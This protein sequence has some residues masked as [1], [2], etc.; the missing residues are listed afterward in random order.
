MVDFLCRQAKERTDWRA[1]KSL[2][3]LAQMGRPEALG[4]SIELGLAYPGSILYAERSPTDCLANNA[5]RI[6]TVIGMIHGFKTG[7]ASSKP[8]TADSTEMAGVIRPSP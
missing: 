5:M 8:S 7:V 3:L 2:Q 6:A 1:A 4:L